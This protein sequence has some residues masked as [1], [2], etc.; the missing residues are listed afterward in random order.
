MI[1]NSCPP[2]TLSLR[3]EDA[4]ERLPKEK[5]DISLIVTVR[6]KF[7]LKAHKEGLWSICSKFQPIS[8]GLLWLIKFESSQ[9]ALTWT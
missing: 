2:P 8:C 7:N 9:P 1:L 4:S 6:L 3:K 5:S